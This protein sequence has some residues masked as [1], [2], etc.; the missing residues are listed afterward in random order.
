MRHAVI[1]AGGVGTRL[2][3]LS[4]RKRPKQMLRLFGGKSLLRESFDR[5]T[6]LLEPASIYVITVEEHLGLVRKELPEIPEENL[7][8]EPCGRDTANAVGLAAAVLAQRDPEGVM[9]IF[10]ADHLI[11]PQ[12]RFCTAVD[13]AFK[14]AE[15]NPDA[16]VTLGVLPTTPESGFGYVRRGELLGTGVYRVDRFVEKPDTATAE[17][18]LASG[19]YYWNS[20]MFTWRIGTILREVERHLP[21]SYPQL[22]ELG[23]LWDQP[24]GREHAAAVYPGLRKISVDFAIMEKADRVLVVEMNCTWRDVGSWSALATVLGGDNQGNASTGNRVIH[25]GSRGTMAASED[26]EHLIATIG[27]EDL[28]IVHSADATLVCR[29]DDAQAIR[30]LV[31]AVEA[32]SGDRHL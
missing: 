16:L 23:R 11:T 6:G 26:P 13:S 5:L 3:P 18:Y 24:T 30:E 28:V 15:E 32:D 19:E 10:T 2:W 25:L 12:D 9:G 7:L 21:E 4:R 17:R 20:G 27:V 22:M 29:K 8:G 14:R 1:M 31:A